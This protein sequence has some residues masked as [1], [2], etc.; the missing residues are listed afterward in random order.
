MTLLPGLTLVVGWYPTAYE[1]LVAHYP[2]DEGGGDVLKDVTGRGNDGMIRGARYEPFG[3]GW[4]LRLDGQDDCV[5][6]GDHADFDL[7]NTASIEVWACAEALPVGEAGIVGKDYGSYVL[8]HYRDGQCWWYISGGGNNCHAPLTLGVWHHIV[9]IFDGTLLKL[10]IDGVLADSRVS[11]AKVIEPGGRLWIGKSDGDPQFTRGAHFCGQV[12]EVR[13]YNR[14][15]TSDEI[16]QHFRIT[17]L[18]QSLAMSCRPYPSLSR[19]IVRLDTRGLGEIPPD[20][21]SR[22][23]IR[24]ADTGKTRLETRVGPL[25]PGKVKR[26]EVKWGRLGPGVYQLTAQAVAREPLGRPTSILFTWPSEGGAQA[27]EPPMKRL[28]NLVTELLATTKPSQGPWRFRN[29]RDGWVFFRL[30]ASGSA[31]ILLDDARSGDVLLHFEGEH[32]VTQEAMRWLSAGD[33][34]LFL[35]HETNRRPAGISRLTIRAIPE[36]LFAKF[37]A[38]PHVKEYGEYDW[39]FLKRHVLPSLNTLVGTG[40]DDQ[41]PF[42]DEWKRQGK[43]WLVEC[44]AYGLGKEGPISADEAETF[45]TNNPGMNDP[46]LDGLI[47]DEFWGGDMP[48]YS[49]WTE[50]IE[51]INA[52]PILRG[53]SYYP[54][55]GSMYGSPAS[56][57]FM[58]AVL[59]GGHRFALERYLPE[60]RNEGAAESYL[61]SV[62]VQEAQRWEKAFPG[63]VSRMVVCFGYFSAPPESL[64]VNPSVNHKVYLDMQFN[65]VANDP[66]FINV[67]GLMTYLCSYADEETVRWAGKL[68]R[69]YAIEGRAERLSDD[70]YILPHLV[71]GDFEEGLQG[72]DIGS[73]EHDSIKT[74]SMPGF[75]WL[76]GRY[77]KTSQGDTFVVLRRSARGPNRI[78]QPIR[79]LTPDRLYS[80]RCYSADIGDLSRQQKLGL[81][82]DIKGAE[83]ILGKSFQHVFANC[84]SHH[85]P[86]YD[87]KNRAWMNY[88]W[89]IFRATNRNAALVLTDWPNGNEPGGPIG[90]E[91]AVNFVQVQ[92]YDPE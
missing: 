34:V 86:P 31:R 29:P 13:I 1:G 55:C 51:R 59:K 53:K 81:A 66:A 62:L 78:S 70:P 64:D 57:A 25:A 44:M 28:N 27:L 77:P 19:L 15:L 61:E 40:T 56:E 80:V 47:V 42:A 8:T 74:R 33:H 17:H 37:G 67:A 18:S 82:L 2:C 38:H 3:D 65:V 79:E 52:N 12:D 68:F 32:K 24:Q 5:D 22:I 36:L 84:Y 69:H 20:T 58:R 21:R 26:F 46:L 92:P 10:Y 72:W 89:L 4:V 83:L 60:Q 54:Y 48:Q 50:A 39:P 88:H 35:V 91:I 7:R 87:D 63:A 23:V 45:W 71:N 90:Q 76:Q 75:S 49:A 43:R 41:R 14:A 16:Q 11:S 85:L 73:A 30:S 6:C 9:G